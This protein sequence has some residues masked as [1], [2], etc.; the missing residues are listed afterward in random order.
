MLAHP[1]FAR[2]ALAVAAGISAVMP[3]LSVLAVGAGLALLMPGGP[4][5]MAPCHAGWRCCRPSLHQVGESAASPST[6]KEAAPRLSRSCTRYWRFPL[7]VRERASIPSSRRSGQRRDF[8]HGCERNRGR[9]ARGAHG[10]RDNEMRA[11][12][13]DKPSHALLADKVRRQRFRCNNLNS[14][15]R[16]R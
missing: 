9:C 11:G 2:T 12:A 5:I 13:I 7:A 14:A 4:L 3:A 15:R 16:T 1:D 8:R 10:R 6:C